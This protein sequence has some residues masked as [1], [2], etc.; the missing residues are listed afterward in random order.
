[1]LLKLDHVQLAMPQGEEDKARAFYGDLLELK[2]LEKPDALKGRGGVWFQAE[3]FAVHLGVMKDFMPA[4]K[5][6]PAFCV[7][8]IKTLYKT[9]EL[10]KISV[11]WDNSLKNV[12]RFYAND[13]FGNRL[14]FLTMQGLNPDV[15]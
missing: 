8:D 12:Q 14:E 4:T 13:P 7:Q 3:S 6:H 5:A 1:M 9:L 15:N 11:N 10:A 2:E